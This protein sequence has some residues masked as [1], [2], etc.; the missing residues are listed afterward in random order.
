[1]L[2]RRKIM[3]S[4]GFFS[5]LFAVFLIGCSNAADRNEAKKSIENFTTSITE[6]NR[7]TGIINRGDPYSLVDPEGSDEM[8]RHFSSALTYAEA[9]DTFF[10]NQTYSEWGDRFENHF[11]KGIRLILDGHTTLD[12]ETSLRGQ[13]LLEEW[14]EWFSENLEGIRNSG[15]RDK[16]EQAIP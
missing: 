15:Q 1:M 16:S 3:K 7:A 4:C 9:V 13:R 2:G 6:A 14:D 12:V 10:L 5:L 8:I 11:I